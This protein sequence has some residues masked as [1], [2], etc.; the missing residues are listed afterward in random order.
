MIS[1]VISDE[2]GIYAED[3]TVTATDNV[4]GMLKC[5]VY[6]VDSELTFADSVEENEMVIPYLDDYG[7]MHNIT[8]PIF[9]YDGVF[10]SGS[11]VTVTGASIDVMDD[12]LFL[13][14]CVAE[15]WNSELAANDFDI[16]ALD[17]TTC[18]VMSSSLDSV[19]AE[20]TS[21]VT[22]SYMVT[23]IATGSEG[24]PVSG[25]SV[26]IT[27]AARETV[28]NGIT[29]ADGKFTTY[30]AASEYTS[31]GK[32]TSMNPYTVNATFEEGQSVQ[33]FM[34]DGPVEVNVDVP[35][36]EPWDT[37]PAIAMAAFAALLV[38]LLLLVI[39]KP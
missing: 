21:S 11:D 29:G 25:V 20:D 36:P 39:A 24:E 18:D 5:A 6:V 17:N 10:A 9:V 19:K 7:V 38:G 27:D 28:A 31:E 4:Y 14:N 30:A 8:L 37:E 12:A 15:V 35:T 34:V 13:E 23:V 1:S 3:S 2:V 26:V 33:T 32:D 16:Y 22:V